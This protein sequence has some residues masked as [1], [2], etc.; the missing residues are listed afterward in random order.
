MPNAGWQRKGNNKEN[1]PMDIANNVMCIQ[2]LTASNFKS[3]VDFKLDLEKFTCLI[4]LNGSGKSTVLQFIDFIGQLIRGNIKGWLEERGWNAEDIKSKLCQKEYV[5]F[6]VSLIHQHGETFATWEG[7]FDTVQLRCIYERIDNPPHILEVKN[8][9]LFISNTKTS[10]EKTKPEEDILFN[11][12]GSILSQLKKTPK[13]PLSLFVFQDYLSGIKS[14]DLLSPDYL[15]QRSRESSIA[16]GFGGKG[17]ATF[18]SSMSEENREKL[19]NV[20]KKAYKQ[21]NSLTSKT[22]P[23]GWKHLELLENF[24]DK[25]ILTEAEHINDG[26]LRLCAIFAELYSKSEKRFLLYD[27]IEN[28][29]NPELVELLIDS[30]VQDLDHQILVT[31]HSP[32]ILNYLKDDVAKKSIMYLY[33][34]SQGHTKSIPFF[35]IPSMAEKLNIMGPGEV[36]ADTNLT[37]LADEIASSTEEEK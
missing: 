34:T 36:Y 6:S 24:G 20:L 22:L 21:F 13:L 7:K 9:K 28:G 1:N 15:R 32:L 30:F 4:G 27:E 17:L 33:K 23:F 3:L 19:V 5:E 18:I 12:E 16:L 29:I 26:L 10:N 8:D 37:E 31:T 11:Y 35:S 14:L 25:T 2:S